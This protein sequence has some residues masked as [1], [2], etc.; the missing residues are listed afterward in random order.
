[1]GAF[2]HSLSALQTIA[3]S[4]RH[5]AYAAT[6]WQKQRGVKPTDAKFAQSV[7][8]ALDATGSL[9]SYWLVEIDFDP[10]L[11]RFLN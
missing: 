6:P 11:V 10:K 2:S 4:R 5:L 8:A 3:K 9:D 1:M 7:L